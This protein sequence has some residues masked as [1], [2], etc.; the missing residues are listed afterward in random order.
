MF[1]NRLNIMKIKSDKFAT[2]LTPILHW[3]YSDLQPLC[4]I[5]DLIPSYMLNII[6]KHFPLMLELNNICHSPI[7]HIESNA[8]SK[9]IKAQYIFFFVPFSNSSNICKTKI[10]SIVE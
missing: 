9:S 5:L 4:T 10:L 6:L 8:F 1:V 7:R 2:C 3:K